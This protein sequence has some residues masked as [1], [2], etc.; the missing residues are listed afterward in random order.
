LDTSKIDGILSD[1][2]MKLKK[3]FP[4]FEFFVLLVPLNPEDVKH[5]SAEEMRQME[6]VAI[7]SATKA[8][9][10]FLKNPKSPG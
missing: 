1:A 3:E 6:H 5:L 9:E 2:G 4:F 7:S 10:G 8:L